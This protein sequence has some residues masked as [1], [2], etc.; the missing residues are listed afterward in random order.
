MSG[1]NRQLLA[2]FRRGDR[3]DN[4]HVFSSPNRKKLPARVFLS[5]SS[6]ILQDG[7]ALNIFEM[8]RCGRCG[9]CGKCTSQRLL[10]PPIIRGLEGGL[11]RAGSD[12]TRPWSPRTPT[13]RAAHRSSTDGGWGG[14][15]G[16]G[17]PE[18]RRASWCLACGRGA[19]SGSDGW[20]RG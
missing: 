3:S 1:W 6:A 17:P 9:R 13:A 11:G 16:V 7:S 4:D 12:C 10:A 14:R 5:D 15:E 2:G 18:N 19:R 8:R 20:R